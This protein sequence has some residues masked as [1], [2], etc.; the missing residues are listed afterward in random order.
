MLGFMRDYINLNLVIVCVTQALIPRWL[1]ALDAKFRLRHYRALMRLA[2]WMSRPITWD[3]S[4]TVILNG[5]PSRAVG[6]PIGIKAGP[7]M[8]NVRADSVNHWATDTVSSTAGVVC[9]TVVCLDHRCK[10]RSNKN[11]NVKKRDKNKNVCKLW[12]KNVTYTSLYLTSNA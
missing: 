6:R 2:T 11:K 7:L 1:K 10:K 3:G 8:V 9:V 5:L 12:I 4:S